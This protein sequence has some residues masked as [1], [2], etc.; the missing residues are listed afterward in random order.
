MDRNLA[1]EAVRVTEAAALAAYRHMGQGD[2][3]TA[4]RAAVQ[5]M[6]EALASLP[7]DGQISIGEGQEG[8]VENL[9]TGQKIGTGN[10]PHVDVALVPLEGSSIIARGGYN[11]VS[12]IALSEKGSFP[13][14]P[15]IYMDKIAVG[16]GLPD[17]VVNIDATPAENLKA[18]ADAKGITV[19]DIVVCMLDRPRHK[20]LVLAVREA[21]ARIRLILDGDVS[22]A[23]A[24]ARPESGVDI[25]MGIGLAPQGILAAAGL[26]AAGGQM[27]GRLVMRNNDDREKALRAGVSDPDAR[28]TITDMTPGDVTFAATGITTGPLLMGVQRNANGPVSHSMV[29]RSRTGTLRYI[30]AHHRDD[31]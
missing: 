31:L 17:G 28:Y 13:L 2:E 22:G 20:D 3:E 4:D 1:L 27:Q 24:V 30:E 21:G 23:V 9:Y 12:V 14:M 26:R 10:G 16:P 18:L 6:Q 5:A 11:A 19:S 7:I 29:M 25:Y 15:G 8:E